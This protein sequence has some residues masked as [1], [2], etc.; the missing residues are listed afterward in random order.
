QGGGGSVGYDGA[1]S[2]S[3]NVSLV[4]QGTV[5]ADSIA[6]GTPQPW[7]NAGTLSVRA[8]GQLTASGTWSNSGTIS[9]PGGIVPPQGPWSS[10][11]PIQ[12]SNGGTVSAQGTMT[13]FSAGTLT[14]G[15]WKVFA[16]STLRLIST[17]IIT[18]AATIVLDGANSN[19][20]RDNG[21]ASA[22]A[23]FATN[24]GS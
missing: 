3:S 21:T 22:L 20:Y 4:N 16:N 17:G 6:V 5:L 24:T 15:T 8:G 7:S 19:F 2:A 12:A 14:G 11:G 23:S 13:N 9:A 18:N 10:S 1:I